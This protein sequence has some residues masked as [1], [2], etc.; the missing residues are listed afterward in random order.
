ME[1]S[2]IIKIKLSRAIRSRFCHVDLRGAA[3]HSLDNG[4]DISQRSVN[5]NAQVSSSLN[6]IKNVHSRNLTITM[7]GRR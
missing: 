7:C 5:V 3:A 4:L 1:R 2:I 6:N